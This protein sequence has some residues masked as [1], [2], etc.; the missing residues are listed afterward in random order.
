MTGDKSYTS[1]S[2]CAGCGWFVLNK[3][4]KQVSIDFLME[5]I[6]VSDSIADKMAKDKTVVPALKTGKD[7]ASAKTGD[8]YFGNQNIVEIM[9]EWSLHVPYV[10]YG[11]HPY[12]IAYYHGSLLPNYIRGQTTIDDVIK[13]LQQQAEVIESQ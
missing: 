10:N 13:A 8:P 5:T 6:A 11:R 9:A 3:D 1:Y 7:T 4:N 12:E 2:N